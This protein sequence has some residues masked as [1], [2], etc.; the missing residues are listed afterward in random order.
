[1]KTILVLCFLG[2]PTLAAGS[3]LGTGGYNAS[4][5]DLMEFLIKD[6]TYNCIFVTNTTGNYT[7]PST[8]EISSNVIL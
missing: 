2:D 4:V 7:R 8:I 1:M 3:L 5:N 6:G